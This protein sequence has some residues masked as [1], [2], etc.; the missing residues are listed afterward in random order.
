MGVAA[1]IDLV[2]CGLHTIGHV[3]VAVQQPVDGCLRLGTVTAIGERVQ[4]RLVVADGLTGGEDGI[5]VL[6]VARRGGG[7]SCRLAGILGRLEIDTVVDLLLFG[8]RGSLFGDDLHFF[9]DGL[10]WRCRCGSLCSRWCRRGRI[11]LR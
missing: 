6:C 10:S 8:L 1:R 2:G 11:S 5:V 4:I 9:S 7:S 3:V